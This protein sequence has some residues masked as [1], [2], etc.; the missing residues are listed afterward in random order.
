MALANELGE[1]GRQHFHAISAMSAKYDAADTDKKFSHLLK[2]GRG[3]V[4]IATLF[5]LAKQ[6]GCE[7]KSKRTEHIE[8]VAT[9]R[10]VAVG[11]PGGYQS[12]DEAKEAA[13]RVLIEQDGM[14][15]SDIDEVLDKVFAMPESELQAE[16]KDMVSD[17]KEFLRQYDLRYNE[18]TGKVEVSGVPINDRMINSIWVKAMETF[19]GNKK[20]VSK[21]V[22]IAIIESDHVPQYNPI[23]QFFL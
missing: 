1:G 13:K 5:Y 4:K 18:I 3:D 6:A 16:R 22:L 9:L 11:K 2:S 17:L 10:A 14:Q 12:K 19:A 23:R 20:G 15:G 7:I 8:R 21:E